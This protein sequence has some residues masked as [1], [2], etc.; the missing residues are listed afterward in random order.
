MAQ[1]KQLMAA[2]VQP[3]EK[4]RRVLMTIIGVVLCGVSVGFC[5][6]AALGLGTYQTMCHGVYRTFPTVSEG[7]LYAIISGILLIAT[8]IYDRHYIGF[9]T[10]INMFLLGYV[11]EWTYRFLHMLIPDVTTLF[12]LGFI[13]CSLGQILLLAIAVVILCFS[14]ALYMVADL[15]IAAYDAIA[16]YLVR[17]G[18]GKFRVIRICTDCIC[19]LIGWALG[20]A[21]GVY[22]VIAA[23]M[24]GP[25]TSFF[26]EHV[27]K[28]LRY[29]RK[30]N[31]AA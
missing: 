30:P 20:Q 6:E 15:G 5:K 1:L 13:E 25:F 22:T 24:L 31:K 26:M 10:L 2:W 3:G 7:L 23:F 19:V 28:P 29:G 9:G 12:P 11:A 17:K 18:I 8:F 27:A 21:P 16:L 4:R 14:L